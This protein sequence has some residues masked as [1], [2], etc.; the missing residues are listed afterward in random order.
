MPSS[1]KVWKGQ[2]MHAKFE[3]VR[4]L[5]WIDCYGPAKT[6][7]SKKNPENKDQ[8]STA[9]KNENLVKT[10]HKMH[11][12]YAD[13]YNLYLQ[14]VY[15]QIFDPAQHMASIV[16]QLLKYDS[17]FEI[18]A[19]TMMESVE[20]INFHLSKILAQELG[21]KNITWSLKDALDMMT[22]KGFQTMKGKAKHLAKLNERLR[23]WENLMKSN[24]EEMIVMTALIHFGAH[25]SGLLAESWT[26]L[27]DKDIA[28]IENIEE[29]DD[30]PGYCEKEIC[31]GFC[32][33]LKLV[34]QIFSND[35]LA[36]LL[37][38]TSHPPNY[39]T[40]TQHNKWLLPFCWIGKQISPFMDT[41]KK[42]VNYNFPN[43][44]FYG[45]KFCD[46]GQLT[47]T[48]LGICTSIN[49]PGVDHYLKK[50]YTSKFLQET[51][52]H[53]WTPYY[54]MKT[55][56]ETFEDGLMLILDTWAFNF[57]NTRS[58]D[59]QVGNQERGTLLDSKKLNN[60]KIIVHNQDEFPTAMDVERYVLE[61]EKKDRDI[62]VS[63]YTTV[64]VEVHDA[65]EAIRGVDVAKRKC[66]FEDETDG[67][68]MFHRYSE[69]NCIFEC[70]HR[71]AKK[72]CKCVP[73][74][75]PRGQ[76][77]PV[78]H[79]L[80]NICFHGQL[81]L[82]KKHL[83]E[84]DNIGS[85][86]CGC[87][88][89]C[90]SAKYIPAGHREVMESPD[91]LKAARM[92]QINNHY[93]NHSLH[94]DL[95]THDEHM[96]KLTMWQF[97]YPYALD[98]FRGRQ[99]ALSPGSETLGQVNFFHA[100]DNLTSL[101]EEKGDQLVDRL[102]NLAIWRMDFGA[103]H[104]RSRIIWWQMLFFQSK[105]HWQLTHSILTAKQFSLG[106]FAFIFFNF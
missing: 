47:Y 95:A 77:D 11:R 60:I 16:T 34:A 82:L 106:I 92:V 59:R 101:A 58:R 66:R 27:S 105:L 48:D 21:G 68:E 100:V 51:Q 29:F 28:C 38:N 89:S 61:L 103:S 19:D 32:R 42:D 23:D 46:V 7:I 12:F 22:I 75:F 41:L 9:K 64:G 80:G 67:M 73:W 91:L 79:M 14:L 52:S 99:S 6:A 57:L 5:P 4:G 63:Y 18:P 70:R 98:V 62:P 50:D 36:Q 10:N 33:Q 94:I 65:D 86:P 8:N 31:K 49:H 13:M 20:E 1:T 71:I 26:S 30:L 53:N 25:Y 90:R 15:L 88:P 56:T 39:K 24:D 104:Y 54:P 37:I 102:G 78:C 96:E 93:R 81:L 44:S 35:R 43:K 97:L 45:Y 84:I 55:S 72:R 74:N 2:L 40:P 83:N 17:T 3:T 87:H 85:P 76:R 69:R